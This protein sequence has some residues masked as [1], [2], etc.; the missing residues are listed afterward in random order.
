[1]VLLKF[2]YEAVF[3]LRFLKGCHGG[4]SGCQH[5]FPFYVWYLWLT[6]TKTHVSVQISGV[7]S[8]KVWGGAKKFGRGQNAWFQ[9]NTVTLFCLEK[10]LSKHKMTIFSKRMG[11]HGP[12]APPWLRLWSRYAYFSFFYGTCS[13]P[14]M[15]LWDKKNLRLNFVDIFLDNFLKFYGPDFQV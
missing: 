10:C 1:M 14:T 2:V 12:F 9:A 8:P 7:T 15:D 13:V 6:F 5:H 4:A 11:G 3:F